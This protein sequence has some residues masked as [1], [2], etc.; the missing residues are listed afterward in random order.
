ML[1]A[2]TFL[3]PALTTSIEWNYKVISSHDV[4]GFCQIRQAFDNLFDAPTTTAVTP[5]WINAYE[6]RRVTEPYHSSDEAL[7]RMSN[8][9]H[10]NQD[11]NR[12]L[13]NNAH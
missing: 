10:R 8:T 6:S 4:S 13:F 7:G 2:R 12:T 9:R 3:G 11:P 1:E 5:A